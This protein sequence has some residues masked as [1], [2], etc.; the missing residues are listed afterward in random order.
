MKKK[1]WLFMQ[2]P[3]E[4][5]Y[6]LAKA[7]YVETTTSTEAKQCAKVHTRLIL[8]NEILKP[9]NNLVIEY[10]HLVEEEIDKL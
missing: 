7:F 9:S 2:T 4:K 8:E 5:A 1:E 10:Y 6:Q 3:K